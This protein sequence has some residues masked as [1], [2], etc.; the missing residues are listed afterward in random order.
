MTQIVA[1]VYAELNDHLPAS[2]RYRAFTLSLPDPPT[3]GDAVASCGIPAGDVELAL[4]NGE[5]VA[6]DCVLREGDRLALYPVFDS[7]DVRA[8]LKLRRD[9][10]RVPRFVLDVHLG[11][12]ASFLRML[13][14]DA[15]YEREAEDERLIDLSR[16]EERVLLSRDRNLVRSPLLR[17][18]YHVR[19]QHPQEQVLEVILRFDLAGSMRTFVRCLRCNALLRHADR[20]EVLS[21]VPP[22]VRASVTEYRLCP[23]CDRVYWRG[24]HVERMERFI[25]LLKR[26]SQIFDAFSG[27]DP[28][29]T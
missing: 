12:L 5:S 4:V 20:E 23:A 24:T 7:F 26:N 21:R 14:F 3:V 9:P 13:G 22:R 18:A 16:A 6:F 1:R 8:A 17:R 10:L 15:L 27:G 2:R 11:K 19:S 25:L 28:T 29:H